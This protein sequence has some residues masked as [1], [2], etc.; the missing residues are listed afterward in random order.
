MT[1]KEMTYDFKIKLDKVD[2]L[3]KKNFLP[4]EIDWI[5]N[6]AIALFVKQRYGQNNS[7][8]AG[9]ESVQ[10]RTDDLR[11]LQIK[12]P[13]AIQPGVVPVRHQGDIYEFAISDFKFP[14]WFL[15]RLSAKAKLEDC[16]KVI[17]IRQ[18]QHD[19]LNVA[20]QDEFFKPDFVWGEALAVEART[21]ETTNSKGSIYIYT[22]GFEIIEIYP[23]YLKE[24]NKVWSGT[25]NSLNGTYTIGQ[26][27]V[28]CDL[29]EHTH[30]EIVDLAVLEC[31]R[32]I[33]HPQFYQLRQQKIKENE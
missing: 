3:S 16:E 30:S 14:Y 28:N 9:F 12:S 26:P 29:P 20:L 31:S 11:T 4:N 25:Y 27:A 18:T 22:D 15:T 2:S 10:K 7:K 8:R 32:I 24:P 23:E 33:E 21:D 17:S 5:L 6:E 1:I 13:S 19:D